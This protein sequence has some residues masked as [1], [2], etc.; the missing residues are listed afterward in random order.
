MPGMAHAGFSLHNALTQWE[1]S[2]FPVSVAVVLI[3]IAVWYLRA[4]WRLA[5][6]GRRW[7][8]WRTTSFMVGLLAIDLALQS[9]VAA[10]TGTYFEAH[11]VQHLLLMVVGPP[12]L[13]LGAPSTLLLQ[14]SSRRLKQRWLDVLRSAPFAAVSHPVVAWALYYGVMFVFFLTP[15]LNFAML[16]MWVM[17]LVNIGFLFGAT[18]F[19]WPMV[20]VDP[21]IHWKMSYPARMLNILLGSGVEAFLGVAILNSHKP[22]ASMYTLSS[23]KTGGGILWAATEVVTL[24]AFVPIFVQWMHSEQRLAA[25]SDA[26]GGGSVSFVGPAEDRHELDAEHRGGATA[27]AA[28]ASPAAGAAAASS[29]SPG[30]ELAS[31][32]P[33]SRAARAAAAEA[34]HRREELQLG[35]PLSQLSPWEYAWL[36]RTGT[37]PSRFVVPDHAPGPEDLGEEA[38][39]GG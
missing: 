28:G 18:L 31:L 4:D 16:H 7:S 14:T 33:A 13:A 23:S 9:P 10:L 21:I 12:L 25:R 36:A 37:V 19:W 35:V 8:G 30:A 6:R 29:G 32:S 5:A 22:L 26:R 34:S 38:A 24:G 2:A 39:P 15:I 11:V 27:A 1:F 17:D 20:G 3:A